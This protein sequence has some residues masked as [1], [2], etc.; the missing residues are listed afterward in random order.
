[1]LPTEAGR[2]VRSSIGSC[3]QI[4]GLAEQLRPLKLLFC[5]HST[6]GFF[7]PT[8]QNASV[9]QRQ[10]HTVCILSDESCASLSATLRLPFLATES[11]IAF[12]ISHWAKLQALHEQLRS[13][14]NVIAR[15]QPDVIVASHLV[16]WDLVGEGDCCARH[17][18]SPHRPM[19]VSLADQRPH[20]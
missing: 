3:S 18:R 8:L 5:A 2:R 9:A 16:F 4:R 14:T 17:P 11:P 7:L 12:D 13:I 20:I 6:A 1:M 19:C 15:F 10:G